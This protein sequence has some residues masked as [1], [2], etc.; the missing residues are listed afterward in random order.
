MV[1]SNKILLAKRK[2]RKVL[3]IGSGLGSNLVGMWLEKS[4]IYWISI[5]LIWVERSCATILLNF[6]NGA[7]SVKQ[8]LAI[9]SK[10]YFVLI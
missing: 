1:I 8:L 6:Q 10:Y 2:K 5:E 4:A 9:L 7:K 3:N